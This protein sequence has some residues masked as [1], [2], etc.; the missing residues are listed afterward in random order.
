MVQII[1]WCIN[2]INPFQVVTKRELINETEI[3]RSTEQFVTQ[4]KLLLPCYNG[5]YVW[6]TD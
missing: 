5:D 1:Y 6:N 4:I 3:K 2:T